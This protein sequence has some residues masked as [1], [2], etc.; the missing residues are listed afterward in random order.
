MS[1]RRQDAGEI[2]RCVVRNVLD[3]FSDRWSVLVLCQLEE[4]TLRFSGIKA[5]IGDISQRMLARTLRRLAQDG[6]ITRQ[7][8][9]TVPPAVEYSLTALG[10]S[11]LGPLQSMIQW[12]EANEANVHAARAA[13]V[14]PPRAAAQ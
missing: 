14:A 7:M 10:C 9:S 12:A 5:R 3:R 2:E 13:Y 6:L 4:G 1:A 8:H 11:L